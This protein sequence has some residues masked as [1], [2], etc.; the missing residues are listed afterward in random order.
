MKVLNVTEMLNESVELV[1]SDDKKGSIKGLSVESGQSI[2][3]HHRSSFP[4]FKCQYLLNI[5]VGF[6]TWSHHDIIIARNR[7]T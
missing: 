7:A 6:C 5:I 2:I 4:K 3:V 1:G